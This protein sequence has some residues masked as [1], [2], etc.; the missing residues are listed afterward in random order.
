M[1]YQNNYFAHQLIA[2]TGL[3]LV[4]ALAEIQKFNQAKRGHSIQSC[5][6]SF[7]LG[8][9]GRRCHSQCQVSNGCCFFF[10]CQSV[11]HLLMPTDNLGQWDKTQ[12]YSLREQFPDPGRLGA[13]PCPCLPAAHPQAG[14]LPAQAGA[15]P[16]RSVSSQRLSKCP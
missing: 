16:P 6:H 8:H 5:D 3:F 15:F 11:L 14:A 13:S 7:V 10:H 9:Q 2:P 12:K 1:N 4:R